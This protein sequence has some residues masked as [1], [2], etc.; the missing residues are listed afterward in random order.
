MEKEMTRRCAAPAR[1]CRFPRLDSQC[2]TLDSTLDQVFRSLT[3]SPGLVPLSCYIHCLRLLRLVDFCTYYSMRAT[4][5]ARSATRSM[6]IIALPLAPH[7]NSVNGKPAE[8]L[9]YYHFVTPPED[10]KKTS[11]M[12]WAVAKSSELWAGLGKA[13]QNSWKVRSL[14]SLANLTDMR[15]L[16]PA[17]C[18][19]EL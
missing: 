8:H 9:T 7:C 6:R 3:R 2:S 11:W 10:K 5:S 4:Q 17:P 1:L 16:H 14:S 15:H 19:P 13:P 12:K 18:P